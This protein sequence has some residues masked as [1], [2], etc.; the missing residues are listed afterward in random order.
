M[1]PPMVQGTGTLSDTTARTDFAGQEPWGYWPVIVPCCS[2]SAGHATCR[3]W[4]SWICLKQAPGWTQ[5]ATTGLTHEV[6]TT[7]PTGAWWPGW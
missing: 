2:A 1:A 4:A 3:C 7:T 6:V 5:D